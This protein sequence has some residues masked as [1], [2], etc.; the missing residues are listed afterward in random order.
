M[1]E[2]QMHRIQY[3]SYW[4]SLYQIYNN[5]MQHETNDDIYNENTNLFKQTLLTDE[6]DYI[7]KNLVSIWKQYPLLILLSLSQEDIGSVVRNSREY[8]VKWD[9]AIKNWLGYAKV[10][11][12]YDDWLKSI[13]S[14]F[15]V[16]SEVVS[17]KRTPL[18]HALG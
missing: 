17:R 6:D 10:Y 12:E 7:N 5:M 18:P 14:F 11:S 3:I 15:M 2:R 9:K 13:K 1:L 16:S 4:Y 8:R